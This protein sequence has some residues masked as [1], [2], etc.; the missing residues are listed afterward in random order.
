[1]TMA[2]ASCATDRERRSTSMRKSAR[3]LGY[4]F[5]LNAQEM[6]VLLKQEGF[7]DGEPGAYSV[8]ERG[9]PYADEQFNYRGTGGSIQYNPTWTT[10]TWDDSITSE[11]DVTDDK[12][13]QIRQQVADAR[14]AAR[15]PAV[16]EEIEP[17]PEE[18]SNGRGFDARPLLVVGGV[19]AAGFGIYKAAPHIK[20]FINEKVA[21]HFKKKPVELPTSETVE[22]NEADNQEPLA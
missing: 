4:D 11:L 2:D 12:K 10:T 15:E 16:E 14:R 8:T 21:P 13:Q 7:L 17:Q 20:R 22:E 9:E 5:G 1:M 19:I 3:I 18:D 6:N